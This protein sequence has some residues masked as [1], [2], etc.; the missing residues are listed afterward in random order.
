[1]VAYL[2]LEEDRDRSPAAM[3]SG[4]DF[5]PWRSGR[6]PSLYPKPAILRQH[7]H[8][9]AGHSLTVPQSLM[10]IKFYAHAC[11]RLEH[12]GR[13]IITDPYTPSVAQFEPVG[14]TCDI[15]VMS[16]ATDRFHSYAAQVPGSPQV[17]DAMTISPYGTM[18]DGIR[19]QSIPN[20]EN[21]PEQSA[22]NAM[23]YLTLGGVRIL[24]MGDA[25]WPPES[26]YVNYLANRVDVLFAL[27]GG[28]PTIPLPDLHRF[29]AAISPRLVI[30]M[31][32]YHPAGV[33]NILPVTEFMSH[34]P[35]ESVTWLGKSTFEVTPEALP[36]TMQ[37]VVLE[38][39]R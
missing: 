34:Y 2:L 18:V 30:P 7:I 5:T 21:K 25:G 32:Y 16:S 39:S 8:A 33:L 6:N 23:Y 3:M 38:Q 31:H 37:I 35:P 29:I 4:G 20:R 10:R 19:I 15:V 1:M 36:Q 24:H 27:A 12:Q 28:L 13:S 11:F 22:D 17:V 9:P 14:E 26:D